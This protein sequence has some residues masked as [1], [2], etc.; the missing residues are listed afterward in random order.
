[1]GALNFKCFD[2]RVPP[3][4]YTGFFRVCRIIRTRVFIDELKGI[5]EQEFDAHDATSRHVIIQG[6]LH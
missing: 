1:M 3:A 5:A 2:Q 4:A 6:E